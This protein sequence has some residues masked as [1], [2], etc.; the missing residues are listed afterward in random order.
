MSAASR[1]LAEDAA[2][3]WH[4]TDHKEKLE[5]IPKSWMVRNCNS[6]LEEYRQCRQWRAKFHQYYVYGQVKDCSEWKD[7][8][9]DCKSWAEKA[10]E[11]AVNRIIEREQ[12]RI[13]ERLRGH[14]END[15]W[16][17]RESPPDDWNKP[18]PDYLADACEES[19]LREFKEELENWDSNNANESKF[20]KE[21]RSFN[22]K[23]ANVL[24]ACVIL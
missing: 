13:T 6:Y 17:R 21:I 12:R 18:L 23:A 4:N 11:T 15:V 1:L 20:I 3:R 9:D 24:P 14:F 8:F 16:Q 10:D 2:T 7:N 22:A 5:L 19:N